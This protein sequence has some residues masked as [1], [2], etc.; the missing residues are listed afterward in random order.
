MGQIASR[1]IIKN[2][3]GSES[4]R[5]RDIETGQVLVD[6]KDYYVYEAKDLE[7]MGI[8]KSV[9]LASGV[10]PVVNKKLLEDLKL[11]GPP[12]N[13]DGQPKYVPRMPTDN[14]G[15]KEV[16]A[17]LKAAGF[18]PGV[19]GLAAKGAGMA[20]NANNVSAT[21]SARKTLGLKENGWTSAKGVISDNK[22]LV[23]NMQMGKN[24]SVPVSLGAAVTKDGRT[25]MTPDEARR[26]MAATPG[27]EES[28]KKEVKA[29]VKEVKETYGQR[30]GIFGWAL[31]AIGSPLASQEVSDDPQ[32]DFEVAHT[33]F[34][35]EREAAVKERERAAKS[36]TMTQ[37]PSVE[38]AGGPG[39][40]SKDNRVTLSNLGSTRSQQ[41]ADATRNQLNYAAY[42]MSQETGKSITIDVVSGGQTANHDPRN[43]GKK[44]TDTGWTGSHRHDDGGAAD[45]D[46]YS[47]GQR[48]SFDTPEGKSIFSGIGKYATAAGATGI[49]AGV[50]YMGAHRMHAG[51]G[52]TANWGGADWIS[53]AQQEGFAYAPNSDYNDWASK[54]ANDRVPTPTAR[55]AT[56]TYSNPADEYSG[57]TD[58]RAS[59]MP[60]PSGA[61]PTVASDWAS[62]VDARS[63]S[64]M[65]RT[66]A[67][68]ID[69]SRTD[70]NSEDGRKEAYGIL[71]TMMNRAEKY[72]GD[73][74]KAIMAPKQYSTWNNEQSQQTMNINYN[75]DT[76]TYEGITAAFLSNPDN[77]MAYTN[78]HS[79]D[80]NPDWSSKMQDQQQIGPHKFG[81]LQEY[82]SKKSDVAEDD[83]T[84]I[85][86]RSNTAD[87][88]SPSR[89]TPGLTT[90][91]VYGGRGGVG[92]SA[93]ASN[94]G[95]ITATKDGGVDYTSRTGVTSHTD[96][97]GN[98]SASWGGKSSSGSGRGFAPR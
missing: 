42:K 16:P 47:D 55:P 36:G 91:D 38:D 67:G 41:I 62:K 37:A 22:G 76:T 15:Y 88:E 46:V 25:T 83:T 31:D 79:V 44:G 96:S 7:A 29:S 10:S 39:W 51:G 85:Y 19:I 97:Y 5:F 4:E 24:G 9:P 1:E 77:R 3:D 81:T 98:E 26:R 6:P 20:M 87:Y 50:D 66:L 2:P 69:R 18:M 12:V 13:E 78:Y 27:Y 57:L 52:P 94:G 54:F 17:T 74:S 84:P 43:K 65:S 14:Y 21:N 11:H 56:P 23:A 80:V 68:E 73:V 75:N 72:N 53:Q 70:L 93:I 95:R 63:R 45:F 35:K 90:K 89:R 92:A 34:E 60:S 86:A 8:T 40:A 59:F 32:K 48:V 64:L 82:Q 49:G 71:S 61:A 28:T 33:K 30:G 58:T